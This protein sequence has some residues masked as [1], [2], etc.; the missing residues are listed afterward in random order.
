MEKQGEVGRFV[1]LCDWLDASHLIPLLESAL[2]NG[3]VLPDTQ[4]MSSWLEM[5]SDETKGGEKALGLFR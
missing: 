4:T 2:Q 3:A 1:W 5:S